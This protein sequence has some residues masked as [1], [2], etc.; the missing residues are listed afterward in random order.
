MTTKFQT[1]KHVLAIL[2]VSLGVLVSPSASASLMG[3]SV[4]GILNFDG[5]G[6][7]N[8][9]D[10]VNGFAPVGQQVDQVVGPASWVKTG[11][12]VNADIDASG[13]QLQIF[14]ASDN[15]NGWNMYFIDNNP[16]TT[17]TGFSLLN[18]EFVPDLVWD[19]TAQQ[20]HVRWAGNPS[21]PGREGAFAT[22]G[23]E[24]SSVPEPGTLALLAATAM[25]LAL[26]RRRA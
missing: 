19:F 7:T 25:G 18:S 21:G 12:A 8:Y 22:F 17:I 14:A 1:I 16:A 9:W 24:T 15:T 20:L 13:T 11:I 10:P 5:F 6:A 4:T 3:D 2:A 26:R 23:I